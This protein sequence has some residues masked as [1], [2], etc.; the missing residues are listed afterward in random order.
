MRRAC[1]GPPSVSSL[2]ADSL[3]RFLRGTGLAGNAMRWNDPAERVDASVFM[4]GLNSACRTLG[5]ADLGVEFGL[6]VG[7]G[8]FGLLGLAAATAP[9]LREAIVQ[10]QRFEALT[11]TLGSLSVRRHHG[12]VTLAWKPAT[13]VPPC[14]PEAIL[15][16]WVSFGRHLLGTQ[17]QPKGVCL[18][19]RISISRSQ[20][21]QLLQCPVRDGTGEHSMTIGSDLLEARP[22]LADETLND[23]L[24]TW[25]PRCAVA[26]P[27]DACPNAAS[28]VG[29]M[30][31]CG[32]LESANENCVAARLGVS[33]R[34]MQ[35][36]L[37][38]EG[39]QFRAL[40]D[41]CRAH[42]AVV[43]VLRGGTALRDLGA[44]IGFEEQ[45]SLCRAFRRWT[46]CSP[47]ELHSRLASDFTPLRSS[48]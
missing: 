4:A 26:T 43:S 21:E 20:Y 38:A 25:L 16:G 33:A 27:V 31:R 45:S 29:R 7:G 17:A 34:T 6:R 15:A 13:S 2:Y 32:P 46:G 3:N 47:L 36:A 40:L 44:E 37:A 30:I 23:T 35:R 42:H 18:A 28:A 1:A 11:S 14:V 41:A 8:G 9:T 39:L 5:R 22:R 19:H 24:M 10:L 48:P 12:E